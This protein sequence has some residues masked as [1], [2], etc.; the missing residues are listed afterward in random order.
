MPSTLPI[1]T[2]RLGRATASKSFLKRMKAHWLIPP[3][4][5]SSPIRA[6][7]STNGFSTDGNALNDDSRAARRSACAR[8]IARPNGAARS[9]C[10]SALRPSIS[11]WRLRQRFPAAKSFFGFRRAGPSSPA[12]VS[13]SARRQEQQIFDNIVSFSTQL[14]QDRCHSL[15]HQSHRGFRIAR[16]RRLLTRRFFKGIAKPSQ[17][18]LGNLG[19]QVLRHP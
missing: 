13:T 14:R 2:G 19:L 8:S 7:K 10:R 1:R 6:R 9:A 3:R 18:Q 15:Q 5:R 12:L 17:V 16:T 4:S 11:F